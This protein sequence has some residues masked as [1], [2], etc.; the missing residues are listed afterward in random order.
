MCILN[1]TGKFASLT[2]CQSYSSHPL[3]A[4]SAVCLPDAGGNYVFTAKNAT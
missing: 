2:V 1:P 3:L 4:L